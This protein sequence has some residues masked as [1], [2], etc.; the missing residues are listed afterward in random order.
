MRV[1]TRGDR[2]LLDRELLPLSRRP[3]QG[4][5]VM[6]TQAECWQ[7]RQLYDNPS[8]RSDTPLTG[9]LAAYLGCCTYLRP[10]GCRRIPAAR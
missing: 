10:R 7:V 8:G 3:G 2:A 6:L 1:L 9:S 4:K 5:H